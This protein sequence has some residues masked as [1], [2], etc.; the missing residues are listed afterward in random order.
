MASALDG[1]TTETLQL[2]RGQLMM[3][4]DDPAIS[5]IDIIEPNPDLH[6]GPSADSMLY[7]AYD[8]TAM[9]AININPLTNAGFRGV[10]AYIAL[11]EWN[12]AIA[13]DATNYFNGLYAGYTIRPG[14]PVNASSDHGRHVAMTIANSKGTNLARFEKGGA[15]DI[16]RFNYGTNIGDGGAFRT[17]YDWAVNNSK[18]FITNSS[19]EYHPW[20]AASTAA[21]QYRHDYHWDL[22]AAS[23]PYTLNVVAAGNQ[24]DAHPVAWQSHNS[25]VVGAVDA[26]KRASYSSWQNPVGGDEVPHVMAQGGLCWPDGLCKSGTSFAAPIITALA[27]DL[28]SIA[29]PLRTVPE[30]IRAITMTSAIQRPVDGASYYTVL[31]QKTGFG[32]PDGAVAKQIAANFRVG[33]SSLSGGRGRRCSA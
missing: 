13:T 26:T 15:W 9:G 3:V 31:D 30:A 25:I 29:L 12:G 18:F 22:R 14:N 28:Y 33:G 1:Q 23:Y 19:W 6:G 7:A 10:G 8:G 2:T 27:A 32:I 11:I 16:M 5:A 21:E 4:R 20:E 17:A 24:G